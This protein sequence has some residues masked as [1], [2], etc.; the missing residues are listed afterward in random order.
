MANT[1]KIPRTHL[2]MGLCLPLAVLLGY[3]L[4]EPLDSASIATVVMVLAVFSVPALMKWHHPLL[5]L[6][7]NVTLALFILPVSPLLWGG[8]APGCLL[9][10][11]LNRS[12]DPFRRFIWIPSIV[13]PVVLFAAVV[14][15]SACITGG[16]CLRILG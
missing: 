2:I 10:A 5:I 11:V 15:V 1:I 7:W 16:I 12:V 14:L 4:A 6:G 9:F 13:W 3:L 8:L